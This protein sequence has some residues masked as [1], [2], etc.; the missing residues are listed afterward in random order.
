MQTALE[1]ERL[2]TYADY[3]SWDD[4]VRRELIDGK[5]YLMAPAPAEVHQD[6]SRE[7]LGQLWT[8]LRGTSCKVFSAPFDVCLFADGDDAKTVVQPDLLVVCD[9][10]KLDGKRCN[11]APDMVIEILSLS[12]AS[13]DMLT[14]YNNYKRAG[15]REY[16]IVSPMDKTVRVCILKDDKYECVD[17]LNPESIPVMVLEGC[18]VDMTSVFTD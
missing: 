2:Y 10:T 11:G 17:Y 13:R 12:T 7:I 18:T 9:R 14:K 6:I 15:V 8:F 1:E 16:W 4:D 5:I 3:A